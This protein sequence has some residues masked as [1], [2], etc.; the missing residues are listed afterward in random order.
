MLWLCLL[1]QS[2]V[3]LVLLFAYSSKGIARGI[4]DI[5]E[6]ATRE[7]AILIVLIVFLDIEIYRTIAHISISVVKYLFYK[8]LLLN[9]MAR[10]M[11][12]N[13]WW[14][15][16]QLLHRRVE[17]AS[18]V[19]CYLHWFQLLQSCLLGNFILTL[20][21]IVLQVAY[22]SDVAYIANLVSEVLQVSEQYVEGD[23]RTSMSQVGITIYGRS[24]NIHSYMSWVNW[25][26]SL[27]L[28]GKGIVYQKSLFHKNE[29]YE[30][31][32]VHYELT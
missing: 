4:L 15:H 25:L 19:L 17:A 9:D 7:N 23:G 28:V 5:L 6:G 18:V 10:S 1:P 21:G 3:S 13:R 27:F 32:I 29:N 30:L 31:C 26:K 24:A 14:Q 11:R 22:I 20:V 16:I 2:K 8:L 12:L